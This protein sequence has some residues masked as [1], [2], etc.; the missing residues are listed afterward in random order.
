MVCVKKVVRKS[1]IVYKGKEK[2]KTTTNTNWQIRKINRKFVISTNIA[3]IVG[4]AIIAT[5]TE[6]F[7]L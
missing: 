7:F 2:R 3:K 4:I 6:F 1:V 5:M